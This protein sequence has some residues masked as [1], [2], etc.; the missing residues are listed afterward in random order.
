MG[1]LPS[2]EEADQPG[3]EPLSLMSPAWQPGSLRSCRLGSPY[4]LVFLLVPSTEVLKLL[5]IPIR[6]SP[7]KPIL[8]T[9]EFILMRRF[10]K[11]LQG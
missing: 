11:A 3:T 5:E 7:H 6:V 1:C 2:S 4:H 9:P 10:W 8:A